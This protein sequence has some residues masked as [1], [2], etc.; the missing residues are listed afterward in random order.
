MEQ[1]YLVGD[2][3]GDWSHGLHDLS[4]AGPDGLA[5]ATEAEAP[6]LM[7]KKQ[8]HR[9]DHITQAEYRKIVGS[10]S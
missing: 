3:A 6:A 9:F 1:G 7:L 4:A 8:S 5:M 2:S 10:L